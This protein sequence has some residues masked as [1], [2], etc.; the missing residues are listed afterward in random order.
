MSRSVAAS[1]R[2][3]VSALEKPAMEPRITVDGTLK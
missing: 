2:C 1:A 3:E